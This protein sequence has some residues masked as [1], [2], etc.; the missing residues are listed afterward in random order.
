M[1]EKNIVIAAAAILASACA[2]VPMENKDASNRAK[3][4]NAPSPGQAGLYIF[5]GGGPGGALKK[6]IRVDG[7]CLGESAPKVFF[8]TE[9][10]GNREHTLST[11]SEFSAND[12]KLVTQSGKNYFVQQSMKM[13]VFVGGAKLTVVDESEGKQSVQKLEM[14]AKGPCTSQ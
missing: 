13:G 9:V 3:L 8:F 6:D 12:L 7:T 1:L 14:A 4:F 10:A 11:E 5:R 2:T